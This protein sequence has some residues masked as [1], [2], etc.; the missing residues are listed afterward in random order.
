MV[1]IEL[2]PQQVEELKNFYAIELENIQRRANEI[3]E[4]LN[5]LEAKPLNRSK[6]AIIPDKVEPTPNLTRQPKKSIKVKPRKTKNPNWRH[7]V[8]KTLKE[9][10]KPLTSGEIIKLYYKQHNLDLPASQNSLMA[11]SQALYR[12]RVKDNIVKSSKI[13]GKREKRYGLIDATD[14]SVV[15]TEN[16]KAKK[17]V[18]LNPNQKPK[19]IIR[20]DNKPPLVTTYNWPKFIFETLNKTKRVLSAKEFLKYALV[21]Y[22]IPK[23]ETESTRGKLS[24]ALSRM[25]KIVKS[26][27]TCQ[28][29]GQ[30]GRSYGLSEWFDGDNKLKADFK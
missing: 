20:Q 30:A 18:P 9:N 12:M 25:E 11:L 5:K 8:L 10:D 14:K 23:K 24:P 1:N 17:P 22:N 3:K 4:L 21:Y 27:K 16:A 13:K 7:F 2:T 28:K 29:D 19:T 6:P 15:L 26:L